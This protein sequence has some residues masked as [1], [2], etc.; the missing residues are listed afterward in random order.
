MEMAER[1]TDRYL[2]QSVVNCRTTTSNERE[3]KFLIKVPYLKQILL[4]VEDH[5]YQ[6]GNGLVI[7]SSD[8]KI[9]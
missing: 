9:D 5:S 8:F 2:T 6:A 1:E 3:I 4:V 7:I